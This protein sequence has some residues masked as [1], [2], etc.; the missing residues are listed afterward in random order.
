ML[1]E[2]IKFFKY[3]FIVFL[4]LISNGCLINDDNSDDDDHDEEDREIWTFFDQNF[5]F[6]EMIFDIS[7]SDDFLGDWGSKAYSYGVYSNFENLSNNKIIKIYIENNNDYYVDIILNKNE[8]IFKYYYGYI[9]EYTENFGVFYGINYNIIGEKNIKFNLI[10]ARKVISQA[11]DWDIND[12]YENI[13]YYFISEDEKYGFTFVK[14]GYNIFYGY[15]SA[16]LSTN[17]IYFDTTPIDEIP[18]SSF[19]GLSLEKIE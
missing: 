10:A 7:V 11:S 5:Y 16:F 3:Y 9:F 19:I 17:I 6:D 18:I 1:E 8:L 4:L 2:I 13:V 15:N 12:Y 14:Y